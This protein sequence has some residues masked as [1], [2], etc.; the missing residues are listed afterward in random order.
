METYVNVRL[1]VDVTTG[2]EV[3]KSPPRKASFSNAAKNVVKC[4]MF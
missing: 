1:N 2:N 4:K 3:M